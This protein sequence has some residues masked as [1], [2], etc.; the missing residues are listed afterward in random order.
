M[1]CHW[2]CIL[3]AEAQTA[4][5]RHQLSLLS[6][7]CLLQA[8]PRLQGGRGGQ[9]CRRY[10]Q[11]LR[12]PSGSMRRWA[13]TRRWQTSSPS[14]TKRHSP[15]SPRGRDL[16]PSTDSSGPAFML[17]TVRNSYFTEDVR[18]EMG[19]GQRCSCHTELSTSLG[20]QGNFLF[21]KKK[22]GGCG[23]STENAD[24]DRTRKIW[25]HSLERATV[26]A[27]LACKCQHHKN[28]QVIL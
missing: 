10:S 26:L 16:H 27:T 11:A 22:K 12:C 18:R 17:F 24:K 4:F 20:K 15:L 6:E 2:Y 7:C 13:G 3:F 19:G 28:A 25:N 1:S 9:I 14:L 5:F 23:I 8:T 21:G